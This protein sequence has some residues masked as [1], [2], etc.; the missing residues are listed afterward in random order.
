MPGPMKPPEFLVCYYETTR[1]CDQGCPHCMTER[2]PAPSRPELSTEEAKRLVLDELKAICP[3]GAVSF[4]GGEVLRRNDHL[5]LIA[6][7]AKNGLYSF[8]NTSGGGLNAVRIRQ[9][10]K[11]AAGRLTM[12]FSL[13][14]VEEDVQRKCRSGGRE[15]LE[16]LLK[17]CDEANVPFFVLIT[18]SKQNLA[19]LKSTIG[20]LREKRIELVRSPFVPRGAAAKA[21]HLCFDRDDME[22]MIH[23]ALRDYPLCYVSHTPFFAAPDA[24]RLTLGGRTLSLGNLGCQ[25][26]RTL[27][28]ISAEGD[29]APCIHLLDTPVACGNVRERPLSGIFNESGMMPALRGERPV[30]GKCGRCRYGDSCRGCRAL[31]YYHAGDPLAEDPSCFFDP[32]DIEER[33]PYEDMQTANTRVFLNHMAQNR[34][35]SD[36]FGAR[37]RM[38]VTL[39][40]LKSKLDTLLRGA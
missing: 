6:H 27:I 39:L 20:W 18:I 35:W 15:P 11:A 8:V 5:E 31:A 32:D 25:A 21:R 33:S 30:K 2:H 22:R 29:V 38:G 24:T 19:S 16:R 12:G 1:R 28:G 3:R 10:K 4:S 14:S 17:I 36:I 40:G 34:P 37:G 23:P 13:D 26:G 9:L 7:N